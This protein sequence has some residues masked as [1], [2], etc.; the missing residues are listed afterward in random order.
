M[1]RERKRERERDSEGGRERGREEART[2]LYYS[3]WTLLF[4]TSMR[5]E[6]CGTTRMNG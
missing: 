5:P 3:T 4:D 1:E 2:K 6:Y